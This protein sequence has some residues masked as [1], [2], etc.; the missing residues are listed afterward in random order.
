[1]LCSIMSICEGFA[2]CVW[3]EDRKDRPYNGENRQML[4]LLFGP[5]FQHA[6]GS[7]LN[8]D[9]DVINTTDTLQGNPILEP[10]NVIFA[11]AWTKDC[12]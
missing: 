2:A 10:E 6:F 12:V 5:V 9:M 11:F 8:Q 7:V 4:I 1:M 3:D